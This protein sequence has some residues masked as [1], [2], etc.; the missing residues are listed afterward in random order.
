MRGFRFY[1]AIVFKG[2]DAIPFFWAKKL[3]IGVFSH[4]EDLSGLD[5][6]FVIDQ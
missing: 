5:I 1:E 6:W 3:L 4:G 2:E